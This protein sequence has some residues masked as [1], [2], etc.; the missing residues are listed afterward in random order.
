[1]LILAGEN[2]PRCPIR[3]IENYVRVLEERGIEHEVYRYDA[4]HGSLVDDE[5]VRQ[6]R[7]ELDFTARHLHRN[8]PSDQ[9]NVGDQGKLGGRANTQLFLDRCRG[10]AA[11][12]SG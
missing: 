5:V 1:M 3:Q 6:V 10:T 11:V 4:G 12:T 2:D 8:Q 7:A 9:G